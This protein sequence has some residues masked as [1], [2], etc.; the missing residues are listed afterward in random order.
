MPLIRQ[1]NQLTGVFRDTRA[2]GDYTVQV[3]VRDKDE[4][5]GTRRAR[6]LVYQQDLELDNAAADTELAA[7]LA[8][9]TG[10]ERLAPE[11]LPE[12][13]RRL[14]KGNA[15]LLI[16][17]EPRRPSGIP[18]RFALLRR[19]VGSRMGAAEAV[20]IG[21]KR[22]AQTPRDY[23][24][25]RR[26]I[27]NHSMGDSFPVITSQGWSGLADFSSRKEKSRSSE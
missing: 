26:Q 5:V 4:V 19:P 11:K 6:I 25:S 22:G 2:S 23:H 18:G 15:T 17:Q 21:V 20:G 16:Q 10:G 27:R 7:N 13:V 1:D 3:S 14:A 9:M 8:A 12:L 24:R